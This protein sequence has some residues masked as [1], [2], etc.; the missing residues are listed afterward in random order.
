MEIGVIG[1]WGYDN[2]GDLAMLAALRQ[3]LAPHH[4]VPIDTGF[5]AHPD[6]IYRLNR[7]DY[8]ILGGGTLIPGKP[9]APFD[10]FD[11]WA[12]TLECPLGVA[13][14]GVDPISEQY[15]PAVEAL[16]ARAQFFYVRDRESR[17]S[18]RDY[19]KVQVAPDL[20]FAYPLPTCDNVSDDARSIP[21][22]GINLRRSASGS[23][24]PELWLEALEHL[25]VQIKGI[26]LSSFDVFGEGVLLRQLDPESPEHFDPALYR[27][28]DLM[29]GTAFHSI[30]FAVQAAVPVIAIN[31]APKVRQFMA[32]NGLTR[33][34]LAS[35]E[36]YRL[37][38][39]VDEL[40]SERFEIATE[41]R[42]I[43]ERLHRDAQQ[44]IQTIRRQ[45]EA[46]EPRH[47]RTGPRI[48]IAVAGSESAEK[49][50]R[51]RASCAAQ[52]YENVEVL[53]V[54]A[55]TQESVSARLQHALEQ[56]SGTYLTWI[57]GGDWFAEDA[58]DCLI[59]RM[60]QDSECDVLYTDYWLISKDDMLVGN[61]RVPEIN[62]LYRRD[63]VGPCFLVRKKAINSAH[64]FPVGSPLPAYNLWLEMSSNHR[65][66]A[67][68]ASLMYSRR[69]PH[70]E[71]VTERE[72]A[73]RQIWRKNLPGLLKVLWG[74]IGSNFGERYI[75]KPIAYLSRLLRNVIHAR[76]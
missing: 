65:F 72:R 47:Q 16:L 58:V 76:H 61:H 71:E 15:W 8:V 5:P 39:L 20:T 40:L 64:N 1:W 52:S 13:G 3:G 4:V 36:H 17:S 23:I 26:P 57:N 18:L 30:L 12:D 54:D 33:Y 32:D 25:P 2:Q 38:G 31:Y 62:K 45:I 37:S 46:N 55:D 48:T 44:N 7:L 49:D 34:L 60:E 28:I 53:L 21:V 75:V 29:I 69:Q 51:T 42:A 6:T 56:S 14:L 66:D 24:E 19:P 9:T 10:T 22:C 43:R 35:D 50:R 27:Q 73:A 70:S 59:S 11:R 68:H 41:L 63:V 74:I 67:F